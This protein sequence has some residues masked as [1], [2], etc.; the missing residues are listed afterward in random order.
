MLKRDSNAR[1]CIFTS[2]GDLNNILSWGP[3][4]PSKPWDLIISF[5]G[6]DAT[7]F[8]RLRA[9]SDVIVRSKGGK[10]QNLKKLFDKQPG[11]FDRYNFILVCDD[12]I[13]I[14]FA[15]I[16][17][18]F[19]LSE[20]YD[21][22]VSQPSFSPD[23]RVS[24]P[25]T[26]Q[27]GSQIRL[28]NFVE[29]TCPLFRSDKLFEFLRIYNGEL[30]GWGIDWWFSNFLDPNRN[31]KIAI[32]DEVAVTNP[33]HDQRRGGAR[34][35]D[36]LQPSEARESH[37][38]ETAQNFH[39]SEYE[40]RTI[41]YIAEVNHSEPLGHLESLKPL[42]SLLI[43]LT[44]DLQRERDAHHA[45]RWQLEHARDE[46]QR[47]AIGAAADLSEETRRHR[48]AL[49]TLENDKNKLADHNEMLA[50]ELAEA[51]FELDRIRR[52]FLWRVL[53][54]LQRL[55]ASDSGNIA[56]TNRPHFHVNFAKPRDD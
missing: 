29:V 28:T 48:D 32:V 30:V 20:T 43:D 10:F 47:Q 35:I 51:R 26:Q 15:Q 6:D 38:R 52:S 13:H 40:I 45:T 1:W 55:P 9:V 34:E 33:R 37:W 41:A 12:D 25:T 24:H 39:L 3:D 14:T 2:A 21:F 54:P 31:R 7:E 4:T 22:W 27:T 16:T 36:A 53:K 50:S 49:C 56:S 23:G 8:E 44:R 18:L 11:L 46:L 19:E 42:D 5:Y 17:R